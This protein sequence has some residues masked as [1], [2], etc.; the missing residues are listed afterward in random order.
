MGA[1]GRPSGSGVNSYVYALAVSGSKLYA[2]G[3]FTTAGTNV[4]AYAAMAN[5]P[6]PTT[7]P[8]TRGWRAMWL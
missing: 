8:S 3:N 6:V 4:S 1:T 5:L 7:V 2:G